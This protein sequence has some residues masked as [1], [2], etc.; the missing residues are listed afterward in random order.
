MFLEKT[1][2]KKNSSKSDVERSRKLARSQNHPPLLFFFTYF[3]HFSPS[4]FKLTRN[5]IS[6]DFLSYLFGKFTI[7][8]KCEQFA[9]LL[10]LKIKHQI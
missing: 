3:K 7:L 10:F 9:T 1:Q 4:D 6:E 8:G 5:R 2:Q